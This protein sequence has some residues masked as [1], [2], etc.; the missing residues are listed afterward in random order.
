MVLSNI[1]PPPKKS[2][3]NAPKTSSP[4]LETFI[5]NVEKELFKDTSYKKVKDNLSKAERN[6]L[7]N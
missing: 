1:P 6:S 5:S 3:W 4:Q 7:N 2:N